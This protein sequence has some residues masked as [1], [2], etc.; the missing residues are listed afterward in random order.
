M[1]LKTLVYCFAIGF[2][3]SIAYGDAPKAE[4][5]LPKK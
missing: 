1:N 5:H 3:A 2:A 4:D